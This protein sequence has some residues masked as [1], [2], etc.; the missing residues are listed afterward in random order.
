L[1][2][3]LL[4][5]AC[6]GDSSNPAVAGIAVTKLPAT[7][8]YAVGQAFSSAGLEVTATYSDA[9]SKAVTGWTLSWTGGELRDGNTAITAQEGLKDV[10][11]T[12][13]DAKTSF[14]IIVGT[15]NR[16]TVSGTIAT[17]DGASSAGAS[18]QLKLG[19]LAFGA[20]VL[21][22][23]GG[24]YTVANVPNWTYTIEVSLSGYTTGT[25]TGVTVSGANVTGKDLVLQKDA[26]PGKVSGLGGTAGD[27]QVVLAWT[28]PAD[29]DLK[30]IEITWTPGGTAPKTAAKGAK[31]YTATDLANGDR[32]FN[33]SNGYTYPPS[34][35]VNATETIYVR[36][37]GQE[38]YSTGT[39]AIRYYDSASVPP[40][41]PTDVMVLGTPL[42]S[43][44]VAWYSVP[45]ATGYKVYRS[46]SRKY[47][48]P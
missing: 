31:T 41:A 11:V 18:V 26:P 13:G 39:Y 15:A 34:I 6:G 38:G 7:V 47:P 48:S 1:A 14:S 43:C 9:S 3:T 2:A 37:A 21:A 5:T 42:S 27:G 36:V 8:A 4:F 29:T 16:Y 23:T 30:E 46:G 35:D 10:T 40:P 12:F 25:I 45:G 20:P 33:L 32:L 22:G 28:D 19:S 24:T 44:T 17:A